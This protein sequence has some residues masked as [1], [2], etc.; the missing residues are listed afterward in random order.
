MLIIFYELT[1][2]F[3]ISFLS[4]PL[5]KP[6]IYIGHSRV[7]AWESQNCRALSLKRLNKSKPS[8]L[9][10]TY[11]VWLSA[12]YLQSTHRVLY[13]LIKDNGQRSYYLFVAASC[14]TW[15]LSYLPLDPGVPKRVVGCGI[16]GGWPS[17]KGKD[18]AET[19][20]VG[21]YWGEAGLMSKGWH[22]WTVGILVF[23]RWQ[24]WQEG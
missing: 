16:E 20:S 10:L 19:R 2:S 6:F 11:F 9:V 17:H 14:W 8:L 5:E 12:L 3:S 23:W 22:Y 24:I 13:N 21:C 1:N 15:P 18:L 4:L 7:Y